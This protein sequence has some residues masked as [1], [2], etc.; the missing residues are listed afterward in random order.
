[1]VANTMIVDASVVAFVVGVVV[2]IVV[3]VGIDLAVIDF[4]VVVLVVVMM[5]L[6]N[7]S[8]AIIENESAEQVN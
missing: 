2:V 7:F 6:V 1:M 8:A 4:V 3:G 5:V